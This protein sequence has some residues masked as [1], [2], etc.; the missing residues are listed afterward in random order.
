MPEDSAG[1]KRLR[2]HS[3]LIAED[4]PISRAYLVQILRASGLTIHEAGDGQQALEVL[5]R[6]R[7][8]L[9]LLDIH[10]PRLR[11]DELAQR[12]RAS[13]AGVAHR[14]VPLLAITAFV[15]PEERKGYLDVGFTEVYGK[16]FAAEDLLAAITRHLSG[17]SF[18]AWEDQAESC[19]DPAG[20]LRE[21]GSHPEV[22]TEI[23]KVFREE[24]PRRIDALRQAV[25][26][27]D[28]F[29]ISRVAH[30]LGST[31][32][33]FHAYTAQA[34]A[35]RCEDMVNAG[36]TAEAIREAEELMCLLEGVLETVRE[37]SAHDARE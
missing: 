12:I 28:S 33:T 13:E 19:Y 17:Q 14:D 30:S 22:L 9:V 24:V 10:M 21:F 27:R 8:E 23:L 15:S 34:A 29:R 35:R 18:T 31:A 37:L 2:G 16:P 3:V 1:A 7:C 4:D 26:A 5:Q 36:E 6:E 25:A 11:G 32:A 20:F